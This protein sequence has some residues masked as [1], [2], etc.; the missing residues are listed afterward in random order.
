[1]IF[2]IFVDGIIVICGECMLF[3]I[4]FEYLVEVEYGDVKIEGK[5]MIVEKLGNEI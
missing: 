3:G 5:V 1:M 4:C 2:W